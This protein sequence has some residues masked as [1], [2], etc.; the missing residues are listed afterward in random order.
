MTS[1]VP[2]PAT[3]PAA[4]LTDTIGRVAVVESR[5]SQLSSDLSETAAMVADVQNVQAAQ[6]EQIS[7]LATQV[8]LLGGTP[9]D[10]EEAEDSGQIVDW[11]RLD[12]AAAEREWQRLY[13]WVDGW[14]V[15][16]YGVTVGQ[17]RLCWPHH[18]AVREEL[19]WLR[20]CWV[21]AYR[22]PGASPTAAAEWHTR[23]LPSCLDRIRQ[24]T[25]QCNAGK[26]LDWHLPEELRHAVSDADLSRAAYWL[27]DGRDADLAAR[28]E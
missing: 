15:P 10:E 1:H 16:T 11:S 8:S 19:S 28:Q 9:L 25:K 27:H 14:L 21:A 22:A 3:G 18:P 17:L 20:C 24:H 26:H 23:W 13:E 12:R 2:N 4:M 7:R 5:V 6:Q